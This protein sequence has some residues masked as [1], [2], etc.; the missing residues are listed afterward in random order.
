MP[1][2]NN[3]KNPMPDKIYIRNEDWSTSSIPYDNYVRFYEAMC[4]KEFMNKCKSLMAFVAGNHMFKIKVPDNMV[5]TEDYYTIRGA[6]NAVMFMHVIALASNKTT[7]LLD[8]D[9]KVLVSIEIDRDKGYKIHLDKKFLERL[10]SFGPDDEV[11]ECLSYN[12]DIWGLLNNYSKEN[13]KGQFRVYSKKY[14]NDVHDLCYAIQQAFKFVCTMYLV[15]ESAVI[16]DKNNNAI[17]KIVP[18][19][20]NKLIIFDSNGK[21][22]GTF[23]I[24]WLSRIQSLSK[25][26][27]ISKITT[28]IEYICDKLLDNK[29]DKTDAGVHISKLSQNIRSFM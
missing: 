18:K 20:N 6:Q 19:N 2:Y 27:I 3:N 4:K 16:Y 10:E 28:N 15:S 7:S 14:D 12:A 17:C 29:Y 25:E 9:L 22:L 23:K 21:E 13:Y 8:K 11:N 1:A 26:E 5:Y 24:E